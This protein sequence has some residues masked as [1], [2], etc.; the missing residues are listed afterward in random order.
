MRQS[1][2]L[3]A[4]SGLK[5]F[6]WVTAQIQHYSLKSKVLFSLKNTTFSIVLTKKN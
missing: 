2:E 1:L 5:L 4:P 6:I 3:F